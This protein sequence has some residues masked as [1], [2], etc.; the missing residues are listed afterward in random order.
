[1]KTLMIINTAHG[2]M[3]FSLTYLAAFLVAAG[4]M[5]IEG[6]KKGYPKSAWLLILLTGVIFF[7]IGDKI[8]TYSP[9]EWTQVFTRFHFPE[10]DKKTV[11]GGIV[12][13]F[14]GLLL[15]KTWLRFK[16]PVLDTLAVALPLA[17]AISR[18]GCL[19]AGCC[20]GTTTNL[21]WGV[22]Y[23]AASWAYQIHLSQGLVHLHD[24][25][26]LAIHPA[27]LYQVIGCLIIAFIVWKTRKQWKSGGS[28]FLFSV[29]CYA[30]LRFFIEFVRA[31]ETNFFAGQFFWGLKIVQWLITVAFV[32]GLVT[33]IIRERKGKVSSFVSGPVRVTDSRMVFLTA[34]LCIYVLYARNWFT[35]L[36]LST[37]LLI[38]IPVIIVLS[39]KL[40]RR[41]SIAGFRWVIPVILLCSISFMSQK[42]NPDGKQDEKIIFTDAGL[43]GLV[44]SYYEDI[45][46]VHQYWVDDCSGGHTST[47][48]EDLGRSK[49][50]LYGG[51]IDISH[52]K[53][54]GKYYKFSIGGRG[55]LGSESGKYATD[56]PHSKVL[57]VISPYITFNWHY[58]GL[59][60]GF[61]LGQ[62]KLPL[63]KK[64][65][66]SYN[67]GNI[68]TKDYNNLYFLPSLNLRFGSSDIIY[69]EGTFPGL[70]PS[71]TPYPLYT[72]GIGSGLGKTNGT[73]AAIGYCDGVYAQLVFPIKNKVVL[74][75][76]F[77]DNLASGNKS[78]RIFSF[79]IHYRFL[80]EKKDSR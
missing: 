18:I 35:F 61:T 23:D 64:S 4:M 48:L 67:E 60:T 72:A 74:E 22:H 40:Y 9:E 43:I 24:E 59:G 21:P 28:L 37:I 50:T 31:P 70:F 47:S 3:F 76:L 30:V 58:F 38:L 78:K 29:L 77:A 10:T 25:T 45:S 51:G 42:S 8:F 19:M 33:L 39:V 6:F 71:T 68:I 46:K 14:T 2:G 56:Y 79:G 63:G 12:G 13:L 32:S 53:W 34:V 44:G 16:R 73:K 69:A 75:A 1:M 15:A 7:I 11:L 65:I 49:R 57:Y 36:E 66:D 20:F 17:M 27:Q 41:Y 26:S 80:S 52:N 54:V 62:M 55:Y 5:I